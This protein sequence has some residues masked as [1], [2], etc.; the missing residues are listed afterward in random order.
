MKI[1]L[2]HQPIAVSGGAERATLD[3]GAALK[4]R[5][6]EIFLWG[7][8]HSCP[9]FTRIAARAGLVILECHAATHFGELLALRATCRQR[10]IDIILSHG[11]RYNALTPY[12][13][14][15]ITTQHVPVLRAQVSTWDEPRKKTLIYRVVQPLWNCFWMHVLRNESRIICITSAVAKDSQDTLRS[16]SSQAIVIYD[17]VGI[18]A[19]KMSNYR[20]K[21]ASPFQ[22]AVVGRLQPVKRFE[23]IVPLMQEILISD[24]D[25]LVEIA[26]TGECYES[27]SHAIHAAGLANHIRLLGHQEDTGELY[28]RSHVLVHFRSDEAFGRIYVEA[29][30]FGL[31]VVCVRGGG[32]AEVVPDGH[33]GFLHA[34]NDIKGMAQSV[35]RLK[36]DRILYS[37]LSENALTWSEHFS[38]E[39]MAQQYELVFNHLLANAAVTSG[40]VQL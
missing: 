23:L 4:D 30:R 32:T 20:E 38:V 1:L 24:Q 10:G 9:E 36:H 6:H 14:T 13:M 35:L 25:V 19:P 28:R 26:G 18:C 34:P 17:A 37:T 33:A 15:G 29:Q 40:R 21:P 39:R 8:W 7:P 2:S 11:R 3:L 27:I 16:R 31:P 22:I 12:F 5:G